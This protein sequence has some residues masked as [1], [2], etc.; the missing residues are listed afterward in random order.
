MMSQVMTR[1]VLTL[2]FLLFA[3]CKGGDKKHGPALTPVVA[4]QLRALS[5][6]CEVRATKSDS[7]TRE[8]RL[9]SGP[10]SKMTI[11]LDGDRNIRQLEIGVW[12]PL[13]EEA[14]QLLEQTLRGLISDKAIAAMSERIRNKQS[15]P[16]VVD[17]VRVNA[18]NTQAP[19][20]NPRYTVDLAW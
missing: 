8:L 2:I 17:G 4:N 7:G 1:T 19:K 11:H 12:A 3:A 10:T 6:E 20:E 18:F 9:C 13:Y 15:D 16:I 5:G 14:K